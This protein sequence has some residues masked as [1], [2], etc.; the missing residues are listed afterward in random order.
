MT[1]L[2]VMSNQAIEFHTENVKQDH[3]INKAGHKFTFKEI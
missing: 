3:K 1:H 2:I